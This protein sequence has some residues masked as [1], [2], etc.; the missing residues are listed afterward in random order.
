M[1]KNL[2]GKRREEPAREP[3][4]APERVGDGRR[5]DYRQSS[6]ASCR[7]RWASRELDA[8]GAPLQVREPHERTR[9]FPVPG[10]FTAAGRSYAGLEEL[11]VETDAAKTFC[12]DRYG[13]QVLYYTELF[14]CFDSFDYA[15]ETRRYRWFLLR[16][17]GK[18]TR[19]HYTDETN[20]LYVTEDVEYL[21]NK[22]WSEICRLRWFERD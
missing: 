7:I 20:R 9:T 15:T 6:Y 5:V 16:E 22:L 18:L 14:P 12:R 3:D 21:E 13:R 10:G 11:Y 2:F 17:G 8:E 1:F 4:M 19:I